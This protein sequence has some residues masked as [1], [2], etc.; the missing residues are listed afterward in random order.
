MNPPDQKRLYKHEQSKRDLVEIY[1]YLS[2]RS[3]RAARQFLKET[4]EAFD[5]ILSMPGI[6]QRWELSHRSELS[7]LRV[8]T[9][10]R[11]FRDYLIFYQPLPNGVKIII[12]LHGA[13]DL[14]LLLESLRLDEAP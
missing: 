10:S 2:E 14:P 3:E 7:I 13:R 8:T 6:G 9:V 1:A 4:R 5:L 11:R 12:I